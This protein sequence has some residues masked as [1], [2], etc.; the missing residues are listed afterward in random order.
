L[1]IKFPTR[2]HTHTQR[3]RQKII[4]S[5]QINTFKVRKKGSGKELYSIPGYFIS[6]FLAWPSLLNE[7]STFHEWSIM[8]KKQLL[9]FPMV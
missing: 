2:A 7:D 8:I 9:V 3:K 1:S 4:A 5:I 6:S